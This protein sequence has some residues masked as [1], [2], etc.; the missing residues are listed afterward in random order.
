MKTGL[1][2][3]ALVLM[4]SYGF[5]GT[6][7]VK[8]LNESEAFID[9]SR[10]ADSIV[11]GANKARDINVRL[12]SVYLGNSTDA[13]PSPRKTLYLTYFHGNEMMNVRTSFEIGSVWEL[14][15]TKR[16]AAGIYQMTIVDLDRKLKTLTVD[17]TQ[18]SIDDKNISTE[19]W[20]VYL[21][22]SIKIT[23]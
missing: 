13:A 6:R 17:T 21:S 12:V 18:I 11:L 15:S 22:S 8:S 19:E 10:V 20:N 7:V 3:I 16:I 5:A 1:L 14:K 2:T 9:S 23:E 4:S